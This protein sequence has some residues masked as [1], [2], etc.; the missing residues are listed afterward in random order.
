M[1]NFSQKQRTKN[2]K[3]RRF[4]AEFRRHVQYRLHSGTHSSTVFPML[5]LKNTQ[6][7]SKTPHILPK[8][9]KNGLIRINN[10]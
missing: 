1:R 9:G 10:L 8:T 3:G 5:A 4:R 6:I 2:E 7:N